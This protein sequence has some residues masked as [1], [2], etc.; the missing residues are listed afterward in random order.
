MCPLFFIS[1]YSVQLSFHIWSCMFLLSMSINHTV[2]FVSDEHAI[3]MSSKSGLG[4]L[5]AAY[6]TQVILFV[7]D[8]VL[9]PFAYYILSSVFFNLFFLSFFSD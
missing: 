8:S 4:N 6:R 7:S 5:I 2:F 3:K 9:A 1:L